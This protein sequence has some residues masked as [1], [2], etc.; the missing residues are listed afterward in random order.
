M[1]AQTGKVAAPSDKKI[2]LPATG[3][4]IDEKDNLH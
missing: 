3:V 1:L 2:R 4:A